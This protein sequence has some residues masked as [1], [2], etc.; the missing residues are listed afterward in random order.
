MKISQRGID[1]VKE[2][3]GMYLTAYRCPA[4]VWTIGYGHTGDVQPGDVIT[5]AWAEELLREDM[6]ASEKH[7][8]KYDG[9]YHWNQN[10]FDALTSFAFNVGSIDQLTANG[11]R[12][13]T[14]IADKM[15]QYNKAAGRVLAGLTRRR[16]AERALFLEGVEEPAPIPDK[17]SGWHQEADGWRYYLGDTGQPVCNN[18]YQDVDGKWYWFDGAGR[19]VHD[20]WYKYHGHWYYLGPDGAM[21]KGLQTI[22]GKWYCLDA[23]G[24]MTTA[25]VTLTPGDDGALRWPGLAQ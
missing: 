17:P 7:V 18:W 3:E 8:A 13:L 24:K 10:Q 14:T 6:A 20:V 15:L 1:L 16:Q 22:D 4:G 5:A 21:V 12:S 25:P 19:M 2:F 9:I 11:T 23:D